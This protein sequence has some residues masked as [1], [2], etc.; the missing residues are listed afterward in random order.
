MSITATIPASLLLLALSAAAY[1]AND[2]T[3][4]RQVAAQA[5]G[6]VD[7]SN[8]AGSIEVRGWDRPEVSVH[9]ELGADVE[10]VDVKSE[11]GRTIIK[12]VLPEHGGHH[13]EAELN[14]QI[15]KDSELDVSVVSAGITVSG[16]L[17]VQRLNAVS[18]DVTSELAGSDLDLKTVSGDIRLKGHGQPARLHVSTVSGDVHVEH[19]A[20]DFESSTVSGTLVVSLDS[21]RS[22]RSRST[23]GDLRFEARLTRG[24][25]VDVTSVSGAVNLRIPADG[26]FA[27]EVSSFSGDLSDCFDAKPQRA[28]SYMPGS[29]L[30]GTRGDGAGHVHAKTMSGNLRL[31]DRE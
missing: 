24:A 28:G 15:P 22:I 31:C 14:I 30:E 21:A 11:N 19:G 13:G 25:T 26:G 5:R 16:V 3:F 18:G 4:D 20:G 12:V 2:R 8:V 9:G 6:V 27:Y 1:A 23:S 29:S 17:G 10:R 7:V